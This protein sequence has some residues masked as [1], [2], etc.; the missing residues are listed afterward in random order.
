MIFI[1]IFLNKLFFFICIYPY[2]KIFIIVS[3][4]AEIIGIDKAIINIFPPNSIF[5][6]IAISP[7]SLQIPTANS[8][9]K[10]IP[11]IFNII[12]KNT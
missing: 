12:F 2:G 11:V 8:V 3:N 5:V 10:A 4:N 6:D 7:E 9:K 1:I